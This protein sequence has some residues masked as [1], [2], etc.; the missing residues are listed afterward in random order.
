MLDLL[1]KTLLDLEKAKSHLLYS[2][3]KVKKIN[4]SKEPSEEA[5]ET[6]E[7]FSSRFARLSEIIISRYFRLLMRT[8][9]PSFRG[10]V[11]DLLNQA[12]KF[13]WI[14]SAQTW[15]RIREL[16]NIAAH[17]YGIDDYMKLYQ[18][19]MTLTPEILAAIPKS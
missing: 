11:I 1:Q 10:S 7:S 8:K 5:L 14:T 6:L 12:E 13:A 4:L 17:E 15:T 2:Y 9:D 19:L 18:E 16:R 3:E